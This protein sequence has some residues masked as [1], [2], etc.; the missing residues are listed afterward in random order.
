MELS[1]SKLVFDKSNFGEWTKSLFWLQNLTNFDPPLKKFHTT[2]ITLFYIHI[3][4][5]RYHGWDHSLYVRLYWRRLLWRWKQSSQLQ[6]WWVF[7][8]FLQVY[9]LLAH[10]SALSSWLIDNYKCCLDPIICSK[11]LSAQILFWT[12]P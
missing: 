1:R 11:F 8:W 12:W 2:K 3:F 10:I 7:L 6:L 4:R 5:N 9:W